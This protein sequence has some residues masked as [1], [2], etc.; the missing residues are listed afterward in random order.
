M[1][2]LAKQIGISDVAIAKHC[3]KSKWRI[4]KSPAIL[5]C[6][7]EFQAGTRRDPS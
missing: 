5:F 7:G 4:N 3:W 2:R 1:Q 6:I